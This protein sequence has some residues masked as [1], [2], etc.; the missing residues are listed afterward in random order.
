MRV[1]AAPGINKRKPTMI[2]NRTTLHHLVI[3]CC[4]FVSACNS[5]TDRSRQEKQAPGTDTP[6]IVNIINFI[7]LLEPRSAE[8]TEAVLYNT[9]VE[10]INIMRAHKLRGTFLLQYD[11]LMDPRYQE[12]MKSLPRDSFEVGAWWEI[13]QPL[14]QHAGLKWRGRYPWDWYANVG[15]ATGYTPEEREKL[16]DVYM[17]DFKKIFGTYPA[18]V[19]SWFIDAHTLNYLYDKYRIS[20]SCNCKDQYGTDGYT[21]WGG[22]W[23]QAYYPSRVN[24]YMPAQ[25]E[26]NQLPVPIFR[27]LG[28][29]PVRQY[30]QDLTSNGQGVITLEP[31]YK[32]GGGDSAWV[33]WY[34]GEFVEGVSLEF[35]YTQTG[36]ENSFTW[37][38]MSKGFNIQMPLLAKLRDENRIRVETLGESARWF[39]EHY[40]TTPATSATVLNDLGGSDKKTAWFNSRFYRVNMLWE[41]GH[42]RIRDIHL[43]DEGF[44]SFYTKGVATS[45]ACEFSTLPFIDGYLW[46][47]KDEIAGILLKAVAD[48]KEI[49]LEG[50]D[51]QFSAQ[52][53]GALHVS[54][55]LNNVAGTLVIDMDE[56][57][58]RMNLQGDGKTDWY[59]ELLTANEVKLP[60]AKIGRNRIH[61]QFEERDYFVSTEKGVFVGA[62]G[63]HGFKVLPEGNELVMNL[64]ERK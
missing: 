26:Q 12:L 29:D 28:S 25:N 6:R 18:S 41:R 54:W 5:T 8:I 1:C 4:L 49:L 53:P 13:P 51:P 11:A 37:A 39:R 9:V 16:A 22:Y 33:H 20:A 59:L 38:A 63:D 55:P 56:K 7:R 52:K 3:G 27:M 14:V 45:N 31:V 32:F 42:L 10:Q 43:F 40:K 35:N 61:C 19:G 57:S 46:S 2:S 23:G 24:S 30:D 34:F 50:K 47:S 17:N 48:G 15:F 58:I 44:P 36:Q 60:F 62:P 64:A 21:L